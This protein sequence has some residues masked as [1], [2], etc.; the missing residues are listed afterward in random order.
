M[1]STKSF[2]KKVDALCHRDVGTAEFRPVRSGPAT[3]RRQA[4]E[5]EHSSLGRKAQLRGIHVTRFHEFPSF[6][7][8]LFPQCK[9]HII[10]SFPD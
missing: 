1:L 8:L 2:L 4:V 6:T 10:I 9:D 5:S 7:C 3:G